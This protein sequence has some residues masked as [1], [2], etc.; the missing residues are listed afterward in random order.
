MTKR[1]AF[2]VLSALAL[3]LTLLPVP[4]GAADGTP[5]RKPDRVIPVGERASFSCGSGNGSSYTWFM[6]PDGYDIFKIDSSGSRCTLTAKRPGW[7]QLWVQYS[8]TLYG[9]GLDR[10]GNY[11]TIRYPDG[12][13]KIGWLVQAAGEPCT[14]TFHRL[15]G[16]APFTRDA[17]IGGTASAPAGVSRPGFALDGWFTDAACTRRY[18]FSTPLTGDLALYAGWL[19]AWTVAYVSAGGRTEER[20]A[21]GRTASASAPDDLRGYAFEG[22]YTDAAR[23]RPYDLAAPVTGNLTLYAKQRLLEEAAVSY[24]CQDGSQAARV[25]YYVGETPAPPADPA[26][27]GYVFQGWYTDPGLAR[28]WTPGP[29]TGD[30]ALYAGWRRMLAVSFDSRGGSAVQPQAV[31]EGDPAERPEDPEREGH[32]F[33]GWYTGP[34]CRACE[35]WDFGDTVTEGMTLYAGW[36]RKEYTVEF[37]NSIPDGEYSSA[38]TVWRTVTAAHGDT[39]EEPDSPPHGGPYLFAGWSENG[40]MY[41]FSLPV[42]GD[43]TL[44]TERMPF[45]WEDYGGELSEN[46]R[47]TWNLNASDCAF[48][49]SGEGGTGSYECDHVYPGTFP[50]WYG[51]RLKIRTIEVQEG[52][53]SIGRNT[54]SWCCSA[55]GASLPEGLESIGADAFQSCFDLKEVSLPSSLRSIGPRAFQD[56]ESLLSADIPKGVTELEDRVFEGC[57][58]LKSVSLPDTLAS[59]GSYALS[60]TGLRSVRVPGRVSE[61]GAYAFQSCGLLESAVLEEGVE[62]V[63]SFAF[64][65]CP[66]LRT[67]VIPES[68]REIGEWAFDAPSGE[69]LH[70]FYAGSREQW[71]DVDIHPNNNLE[72]AVLHYSCPDSGPLETV[73]FDSRGG[74][75]AEAQL[76]LPGELLEEP[77]DPERAG[78]TFTGWYRDSACADSWDFSRDRTDGEATLYAGWDP[79]PHTVRFSGAGSQTVY[80]GRRAEEPA[81]PSRTGARFNGW[82][83]DENA[84]TLYLF[85]SP[86]AEDL[87]LYPGW[88]EERK[89]PADPAPGPVDPADPA[90]PDNSLEVLEWLEN[91]VILTG[92]AEKLE[93]LGQVWAA[94]Y[95]R[96]GR[97]ALAV[98]GRLEPIDPLGTGRPEGVEAVFPARPAKG[99]RLFFLDA[100]GRPPARPVILE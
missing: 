17:F 10:F 35:R 49:L 91:S 99:W 22:W 83:T 90:D 24:D 57:S 14:V 56:C 32:T 70:I 63:G 94:S 51:H 23:A 95:D 18:D 72:E 34:D 85:R 30:L 12:Y 53:D 89:E 62:A 60:G 48:T 42:T 93:A 77:R 25:T 92:P 41:D 47:M 15:D 50:D 19:R 33:D 75:P 88:L 39:V 71:K 81:A 37:V 16:S 7:T 74:S 26:L 1:K 5:P 96:A 55:V 61:I 66:R 58:S 40:R 28:P 6:D 84:R 54:F 36:T 8:V 44:R 20:V 2:A 64:D 97:L 87:T 11:I 65:A 45:F 13:E 80:H 59:L 76:R 27:D 3:C 43:L 9:P 38:D 21:D 98:P 29:L 79:V 100:A 73:T 78:C 68:V 31:L 46:S 67:V 52:V 4:A 69:P 82:Y 86:V